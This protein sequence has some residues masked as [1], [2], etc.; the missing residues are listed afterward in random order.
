[1]APDIE[2]WFQKDQFEG[3][4]GIVAQW[5]AA[6]PTVAQNWV[7]ADKLNAAYVAAWQKTHAAEVAAWN[8]EN[9]DN[10]EPKPEDLAVT[11]FHQLLARAPRHLPRQPWST[12]RPTARPKRRIE[13]VKEGTDIQSIFFDMWRQ[14]HADAD[15]EPCRPTW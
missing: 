5:A 14:E 13:P 3:K 8:K 11:V 7:K 2:S 12:N 4:P 15:L 9:P 10:P 6:H 1:M